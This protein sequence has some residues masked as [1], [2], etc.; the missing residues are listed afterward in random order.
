MPS[1]FIGDFKVGDNLVYNAGVLRSL[2]DHNG[3]GGSNK[4]VVVQVRAILEA[5]LGQIIYRAQNFNREGVPNIA[6]VDRQEIEG[7]PARNAIRDAGAHLYF[8][9]PYSPDLN[10]IEK[11]FA[12][13]KTLLRKSDAQRRRHME[14]RGRSPQSLQPA[15]MRRLSQACRVRFNINL[16]DSSGVCKASKK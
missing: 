4:L 3:D 12:K 6:E 8:L 16:T 11:M 2:C 5:A 9:P 14:A 7:K 1:D 10:P 13:P 15:R